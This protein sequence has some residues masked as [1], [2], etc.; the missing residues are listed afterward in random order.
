MPIPKQ[1]KLRQHLVRKGI[2]YFLS[3]PIYQNC[4][5]CKHGGKDGGKEREEE[6]EVE[7]VTLEEIGNRNEEDDVHRCKRVSTPPRKKCEVPVGSS[8]S[9]V[10]ESLQTYTWYMK[11][12]RRRHLYLPYFTC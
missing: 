9:V 5:P 8:S 10:W 7:E 1:N 2:Q 6:T 3:A 4:W 12:F 11:I